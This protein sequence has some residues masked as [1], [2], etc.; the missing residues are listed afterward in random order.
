MIK[1]ILA[2]TFFLVLG[3]LF[4]G[5]KVEAAIV[6]TKVERT[7]TASPEY[8]EVNERKITRVTVPGFKIPKGEHETFI[9]QNFIKTDDAN[10]KLDFMQNSIE[11]TSEDGQKITPL[12]NRKG[13]TIEVKVAFPRDIRTNESYSFNLRYRTQDLVEHSGNLYDIYVPAFAKDFQFVSTEDAVSYTTTVLVPVSMGPLNFAIPDK[14]VIRDG[15]FWRVNI[16]TTDLVGRFAWIQL[17]TTQFYEFT[18]TQEYFVGSN[19][20]FLFN[21]YE[22]VI[23]RNFQVSQ[24]K[25][26]VLFKNFDPAPEQVRRDS[27][28]NLIAI[29]TLPA[30]ESGVIKISGYAR[31]EQTKE[32][33]RANSG[34]IA[35]IPSELLQLTKPAEFWEVDSPE[36]AKKA[37]ELKANETNV[38]KLVE[39]TYLNIVNS[40][41]YTDVE[42]FGIVPRRGAL[43]TLRG[44]AAVCMEYSDLF[45]ALMRAQGVP[46][47]AAYG[48][49]YDPR[50]SANEQVGHQWAEVYFPG[51]QDWVAVDVTWG[52]SGQVLIG[53]DLNHLY[54]HIAEASPD[55]TPQMRTK[56]FGDN[57]TRDGVKLN[58]ATIAALPQETLLSEAEVVSNYPAPNFLSAINK[59]IQQIFGGI[60]QS[61]D[62]TI[63]TDW[64]VQ[65]GEQS[66]IKLAIYLTPIAAITGYLI[67]RRSRSRH[68]RYSKGFISS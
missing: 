14:D 31:I 8:M 57:P 58:V 51:I 27:Q 44:G 13:E 22:I 16:E 1:R 46:A 61:L 33:I 2:T 20:P 5:T 39:K 40:I 42:R 65:G 49:G 29:Y 48:H 47:R 55:Q 10:A 36:I 17:G 53:G 32:D 54:T 38:Y 7:F 9:L 11:V 41:D 68:K 59:R 26:E 3:G 60:D 4:F 18:I 45:I 50:V 43:A 6:D 19:S 67:V 62:N 63:T 15:E 35:D 64:G 12:I 21:T 23:P 52:E 24:I 34:T 37:A 66:L 56:Y 25:Q 28:G 30:N